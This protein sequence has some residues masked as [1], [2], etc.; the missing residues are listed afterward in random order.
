MIRQT[1]K[2]LSAERK[3]DIPLPIYIFWWIAR[4]LMVFS[5]VESIISGR[6]YVQQL[7]VY[8][9]VSFLFTV[10]KLFPKDK[11]LLSRLSFRMETIVIII[12]LVNSFFGSYLNFFYIVPLWDMALHL[13]VP[14]VGVYFGYELTIAAMKKKTELT[15]GI[16]MLCGIGWCGLFSMLWEIFEFTYDQLSGANTQHWRLIGAGD[17]IFSFTDPMRY[18]LLDT[19]SDTILNFAGAIIGG[20]IVFIWL[21]RKAEKAMKASEKQD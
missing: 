3:R 8:A 12:A 6:K 18:A 14:I 4:L 15:P 20:I 11:F 7:C 10:F 17:E 1:L 13:L 16:G 19:M 21:K 9:G 2:N 5:A